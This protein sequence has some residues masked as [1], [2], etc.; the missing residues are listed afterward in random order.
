MEPSSLLKIDCHRLALMFLD[1]ILIAF[2]VVLSYVVAFAGDL[3]LIVQI[4]GFYAVLLYWLGTLLVFAYGKLY[5][6]QSI[7]FTQRDLKWLAMMNVYVVGA[8]FLTQYLLNPIYWLFALLFMLSSFIVRTITSVIC[9][10]ERKPLNMVTLAIIPFAVGA[11]VSLILTPFIKPWVPLPEEGVEVPILAT[12]LYFV[13]S[14]ALL[15]LGRYFQAW[16][17]TRWK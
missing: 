6:R 8:V 13:Y 17:S 9:V 1:A 3:N 16:L 7:N 5:S 2:A 14:T 4:E 12:S 11:I 10:L 15:A